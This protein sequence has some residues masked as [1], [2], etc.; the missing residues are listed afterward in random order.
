MQ[1]NAA[2]AA[3][4][5]G[6]SLT[7]TVLQ[8]RRVGRWLAA[9]VVT[10]AG[11]TAFQHITHVNLGID[12]V[13]FDKSWGTGATV[14]PGRMGPPATLSYLLLGIGLL[15]VSAR[16]GGVARGIAPWLGLTAAL[17]AM[18]TIT[19]YLFGA[20]PLYALP[21]LTGISLQTAII[22]VA[23]GIGL[24]VAVSEQEPLRTLL[25][26]SGSGILTRR[27]LP[28]ILALPLVLG[29]TQVWLHNAEIVDV[30][31]GTA[32]LVLAW[33][34][35]MCL[36]LG[37]SILILRITDRKR[38]EE[39]LRQRLYALAAA[40]E[41]MRSVVNHV[42]DGIITID[43][44]GIIES[45]NPSAEKLFGYALAE[46]LGKN[47]RMLMP[48]PYQSEHNC[49]IDN[50]MQSG[51]PQ[52]IGIG[53]EVVG[54]RKDGSTFP[55]ELAVSEFALEGKRF[56]TGIIR[57]ITDRK[58][59][60]R[61]LHELVAEL[62]QVDQRKDEFLA[63][64]AHELRNPLA[65]MRNSLEIMKQAEGDRALV[66]PALGTLERQLSQMERLI[67]DLLDV[68][69]INRN[70]LEL[71]RETAQLQSIIEQALE[72]SRPLADRFH[73]RLTVDL[74]DQPIW[75]FADPVRLAQVFGNLLRNACKYTDPG[76]QIRLEAKQQN[77]QTVVTVSDNGIGITPELR[78]RIFEMFVQS[79][80]SIERAQGGLG[81]G[82]TLV[83]RLVELHGGTVSAHSEGSGTGSQF[84]VHLPIAVEQSQPT[85]AEPIDEAPTIEGMRI[86]VVDDNRDA[87]TS[88]ALLLRMSGGETLTAHDGQDAVSKADAFQ[89]H[90]ILLDI[91]MPK[92]NGYEAC[93]AIRQTPHGK[94]A[95]I[96]A[97]TGWG[98][99]ED[100]Q[101]S[102]QAG[103]D[104]HLIKPVE[105]SALIQLLSEH[106]QQV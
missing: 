30:G 92:M 4:L 43:A 23:L 22:I 33:I 89:P 47:V 85:P 35:L 16:R 28:F 10:L 96:V 88:M 2:I 32:L 54:L 3:V 49:Y 66:A 102:R 37:W 97:L 61:E 5:L 103:F 94:D 15:L 14:S 50:Y 69:R 75:L 82:L 45:F 60:E 57:D 46:V 99:D 56:F 7:A 13:L 104:G 83:K 11:A 63:T 67:D 34:V 81:I 38:L 74:P 36:V 80:S 40:E 8:F 21:R 17:I 52:I 72:V 77:D 91:G 101:K 62:R 68:N 31:T 98:Q 76:G 24:V 26:E 71:R 93:R 100:R 1:P 65:P 20:D 41:R 79:D 105:K 6:F 51:I 55:M 86:L 84:V 64:L 48:E 44:R 73:H 39:Q 95:F 53:R 70:R 25:S 12:T 59:M 27:T 42:I 106:L 19:G 58:T 29:W 90:V 87:A 78:S 18:L 9:L